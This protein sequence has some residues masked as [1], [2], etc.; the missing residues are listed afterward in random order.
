MV[1]VSFVLFLMV[2]IMVFIFNEVYFNGVGFL[3]EEEIE[4]DI[5]F[6]NI[7]GLFWEFMLL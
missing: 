2:F 6:E 3:I 1:L 7:V 4:M 5:V